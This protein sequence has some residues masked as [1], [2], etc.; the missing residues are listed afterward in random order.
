MD[1]VYSIRKATTDDLVFLAEVIIEAEKSGTDKLSLSTL[2]NVTES[3][4]KEYIISMLDE[5]IDGCEFSVSSFLI[6]EYDKK[7]VAAFGGWIEGFEDEMSSSILKSNLINYTFD[8]ESIQFLKSKAHLLKNILIDRED[9]SLQL[10]YLYVANE[11]R[12]KKLSNTLIEQH[13]LN[14]KLLFPELK[15]V[16]VQVFKNNIGAIKTYQNSGFSIAKLF[17]ADSAELLDYL[18]FDE[19]YLMEKTL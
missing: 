4:V 19:K 11:H 2:F 5:E 7:P 1:Q 17:K 13:I 8:R 9:K 14:A 3:K 16:Q 18:P 10:E 6:I 15:K 12:G